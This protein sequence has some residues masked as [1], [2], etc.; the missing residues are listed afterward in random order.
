MSGKR[1]M[2][3]EFEP[4]EEEIEGK[5]AALL[6]FISQ[7]DDQS[8]LTSVREVVGPKPKSL[9]EGQITSIFAI[10]RNFFGGSAV[11]DILSYR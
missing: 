9:S 2:F 1:Q 5:A 6:S 11:E 8:F 7:Q 4:S 10:I 3:P